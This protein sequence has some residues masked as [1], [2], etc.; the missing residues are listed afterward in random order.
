[1]KQIIARWESKSGKHYAELYE[2]RW[3]FGYTSNKAGGFLGSISRGTAL[4]IMNGKIVMG[5]FQPDK[6]K[7]PMKQVI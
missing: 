4:E 5:Y 2:D 6:N 3:G 7:T 1:M